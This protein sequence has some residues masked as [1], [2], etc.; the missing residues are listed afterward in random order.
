MMN[1]TSLT[2]RLKKGDLN[3]R[4]LHLELKYI[5]NAFQPESKILRTH[6]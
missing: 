3:A 1:K 4:E 5:F 6:S 2:E